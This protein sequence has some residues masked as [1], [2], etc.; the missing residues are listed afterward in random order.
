M[1]LC[2]RSFIL[3]T[4]RFYPI[5]TGPASIPRIS[6]RAIDPR[7]L[8]IADNAFTGTCSTSRHYNI[9]PASSPND[10]PCIFRRR[11]LSQLINRSRF[12]PRAIQRRRGSNRLL[13]SRSINILRPRIRS[14][15]I[16]FRQFWIFS[17]GSNTRSICV[18]IVKLDI[19][20][21]STLVSP[22]RT[23]PP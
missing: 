15:S 23:T 6:S 10:R 8:Y 12:P 5:Q 4:A 20:L 16:I 3:D 13:N 18:G 11:R 7:K 14:R 19:T 22:S 21:R 9:R 17:R 2:G 1:F